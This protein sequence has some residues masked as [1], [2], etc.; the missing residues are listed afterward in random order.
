M[1]N[2]PVTCIWDV[3]LL[4]PGAASRN[5]LALIV[6]NQPFALATFTRL[7][8]KC[9]WKIFADGGSNRVYD[10]FDPEERLCYLPH[11]IRG[12]MDSTRSEV[13]SWYTEQGVLIEQVEDQDS[14]DLMKCLAWVDGVEKAQS[15]KLDVV[16]LGGLSGR[17]DHTVHTLSVLHRLR[18]TRPRIFVVDSESVGWVLNRGHHQIELDLRFVGPTC[19]LLPVGVASSVLT[20]TGL[21]W[22][23]DAAESSFGGLVST[24]NSVPPVPNAEHIG[25]VTITTTEPIWWCVENKDRGTN[26]RVRG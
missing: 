10:A 20:T 16:I 6:L 21:K 5:P 11:C 12:D 19:G 23:L 26:E 7:W 18:N 14:T 24:S 13:R 8:L 25:R 17:L 1:A 22:N 15:V 4:D 9:Q 3:N 2:S